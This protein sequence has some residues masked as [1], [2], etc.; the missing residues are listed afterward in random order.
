MRNA[1][2]RATTKVTSIPFAASLRPPFGVKAPV[3]DTFVLVLALEFNWYKA[4]V[5][6]ATAELAPKVPGAVFCRGTPPIYVKTLL[7]KPLPTRAEPT[8]LA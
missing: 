3:V 8:S 6:A 4:E 2:K 5:E 7:A 1:E